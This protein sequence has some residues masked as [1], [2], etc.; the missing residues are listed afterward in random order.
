MA[1]SK[2]KVAE[3]LIMGVVI[4]L[5]IIG[6]A[7]Y[8]SVTVGGHS[9][10]V[11]SSTTLPFSSS[12]TSTSSMATSSSSSTSYSIRDT[13]TT[14]TATVTNTQTESAS[15]SQS[16]ISSETTTSTTSS[17]PLGSRNPQ[18]EYVFTNN[19][20]DAF[21][22]SIYITLDNSGQLAFVVETGY[23]DS[24]VVITD[25]QVS[26]IIRGGYTNPTG[27]AYDSSNGIAY[28]TYGIPGSCNVCPYGMAAIQSGRSV[29]SSVQPRGWPA[30]LA[31][32][33]Y[34]GYLYVSY[35]IHGVNTLQ[36]IGI[37]NPTTQSQ[38]GE[39]P[40]IG[41]SSPNSF[42]YDSAGGNMFAAIPYYNYNTSAPDN[43]TIYDMSGITVTHSYSVSG[44]VSAAGMV[45]DPSTG[46]LYLDQAF[47]SQQ[48]GKVVYD[49]VVFNP[50]TGSVAGTLDT[51]A[52]SPMPMVYDSNNGRIYAFESAQML[53][54]S[55]TNL[56][57]TTTT[58]Q[59]VTAAIYDPEYDD[60]ITCY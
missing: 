35:A 56:V 19:T 52:A 32:D 43:T 27:I 37:L 58:S 48:I 55:G 54:I 6:L 47:L 26:Q 41:E 3:S 10:T 46:Y 34:N 2:S 51:A 20:A 7:F 59:I 12:Y 8:T 53:G 5:T 45:Y 39:I 50:A 38:V 36:G 24:V 28:V 44:A 33:R 11:I 22:T 14:V 40:I 49:I 30:A 23:H 18:V 1:V 31:Y 9:T 4:A 13:T 57:S 25:N 16:S 17:S 29:N 21:G 42:A 60:I 15:T